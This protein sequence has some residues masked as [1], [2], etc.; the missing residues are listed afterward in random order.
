MDM[1]KVLDMAKN[2]AERHL[3]SGAEL[4]VEET[5]ERHHCCLLIFLEQ[6]MEIF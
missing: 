4:L 3:P 5:L 6:R 2:W 1:D